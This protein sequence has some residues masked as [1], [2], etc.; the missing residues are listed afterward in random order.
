MGIV[1]TV[2]GT[3]GGIGTSTF[4]I[5][6]AASA[7]VPCVLLD[8]QSHGAPL[9]L[10]LGA[11]Q[12]PGIRWSQV[13]VRSA[14]IAAETIRDGLV[15]H[16]GLHLL[17]ADAVAVA[18]SA[19]LMHLVQALRASDGTVVVDLPRRH[20][21]RAA[22]RPELD[23]LLLPPTMSGIVAAAGSIHDGTRL[24]LVATGRADVTREQCERFLGSPVLGP[25]RW[26]QAIGVAATA[27]A[28]PPVAT[29][30][31]R[32]AALL[33]QELTDGR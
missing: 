18:E 2:S 6:M 3:V 30:V 32:T 31:A 27:G 4:A 29:D 24:V 7:A 22:L 13:Q 11:E 20:P 14:N 15:V 33:W 1:V 10:L 12:V 25:V 28:L 9:D 16:H 5:A 21:A 8:G 23:V 19:A 17:S 26:Q